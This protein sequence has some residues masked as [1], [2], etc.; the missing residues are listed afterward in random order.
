MG[1]FMQKYMPRWFHFKD[2]LSL[3]GIISEL[4]A[5]SPQGSR[6]E[7]WFAKDYLPL[8]TLAYGVRTN[9]TWTAWHLCIATIFGLV[10]LVFFTV[11]FNPQSPDPIKRVPWIPILDVPEYRCTRLVGN[12]L[13]LGWLGISLRTANE[14]LPKLVLPLADIPKIPVLEVTRRYLDGSKIIDYVEKK[15]VDELGHSHGIFISL[16]D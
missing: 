12:Y 16:F 15:R 10:W 7:K 4:L 8:S 5:H 1:H 6:S 13:L 9:G 11:N 14:I 2:I 3:V